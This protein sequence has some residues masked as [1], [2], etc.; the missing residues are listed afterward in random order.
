MRS[1]KHFAGAGVYHPSRWLTLLG[2]AVALVFL[3][4]PDGHL[5]IV[6]LFPGWVL[7]VSVLL[8]LTR[9][10]AARRFDRE[11]PP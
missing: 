7:L 2:Y 6:F 11:G 8:L 5:A 10:V 3:V 9:P 1:R 4:A